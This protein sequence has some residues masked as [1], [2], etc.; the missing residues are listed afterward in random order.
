METW[1]LVRSQLLGWFWVLLVLIILLLLASCNYRQG[2]V[3][4]TYRDRIQATYAFFDGQHGTSVEVPAGDR[5]MFAYDLEVFKGRLSLQIHDPER[6]VVWEAEFTE[7]SSGSFSF[8]AKTGGLY[9]LIVL[10]EETGGGFDLNWE[11]TGAD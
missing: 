7:N 5:L 1:R 2:W 11:I 4:V 9:R 3:E 10:G 8:T 6:R